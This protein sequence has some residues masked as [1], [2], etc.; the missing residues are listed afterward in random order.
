[1]PANNTV[2]FST[3]SEEKNFVS[4]ISRQLGITEAD[5]W[6]RALFHT[7]HDLIISKMSISQKRGD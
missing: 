6:K 7:Y 3:S 2:R 1:M 4:E 5:V